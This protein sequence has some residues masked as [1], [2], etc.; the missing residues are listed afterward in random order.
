MT[1]A[2]S[3]EAIEHFKAEYSKIKHK[4]FPALDDFNGEFDVFEHIGRDKLFPQSVL[5]YCR[6]A[7]LQS[8]GSWMMY[9]HGFILPNPQQA[10]S[11][12]EYNFVSDDERNQIIKIINWHMYRTRD[13]NLLQ[14]NEDDKQTAVFVTEFFHEW[15]AHKQKVQQILEKSKVEWKKRS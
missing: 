8:T 10:P 3:K 15:I 2:E 12:E 11:M 9:L 14:L 7:M 6:W 1:L 4:G 13:A 5:R